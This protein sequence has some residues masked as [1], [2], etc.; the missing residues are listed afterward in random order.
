[1][2]VPVRAFWVLACAGFF[3][4]GVLTGGL[5]LRPAVADE[6]RPAPAPAPPADTR[7]TA[8]LYQAT[9]A[10]YRA[11]CMGIYRAAGDRLEET[12]ARANPR[13]A[14]PA[15]VMD[16]DETVL[17][18][19]AFSTALRQHPG[20]EVEA[21][22]A[23]Y[24]KECPQDVGL[25]PGAKAFITRAEGLGVTV[26]YLSNRSE[27]AREST[28][29]ALTRLGLAGRPLDGRLLLKSKGSDKSSRRDAVWARFNVAQVFGDNLR[30]FAEAFAAPVFQR[31]DGIEARKN[32]LAQ[33]DK[34]TDESAVH[35]GVDWWVLPNANYGEWEK[36]F[37]T[38]PAEFLRPTSLPPAKRAAP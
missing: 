38:E 31:D 10:E 26:V 29:Q 36:F 17:D 13:P 32:A 9:A 18:N 1:M 11:C 5:W 27:A 12:L 3:L 22:W 25:V 37:G 35:W 34:L 16:L 23:R 14:R 20:E 7:L 6:S 19:S 8:S 30:D 28:A 21:V 4:A 15:V 2:R 33:R 24:E